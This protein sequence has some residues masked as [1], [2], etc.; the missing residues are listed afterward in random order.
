MY[1]CMCV[2]VGGG[3]GGIKLYG[4]IKLKTEEK[5]T[6]T[7]NVCVCV[8]VCVRAC[9]RA[10]LCVRACVCVCCCC[11]CFSHDKFSWAMNRVCLGQLHWLR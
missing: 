7:A 1:V 3:E 10:C 2:G 11:C 9:V 6:L 8:C 5:S 4:G